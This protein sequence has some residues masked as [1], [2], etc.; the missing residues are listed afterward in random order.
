[1]LDDMPDA[2]VEVNRF[3]MQ[4]NQISIFE[5]GGIKII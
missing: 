2:M 1:M 5:N 3:R 4:I